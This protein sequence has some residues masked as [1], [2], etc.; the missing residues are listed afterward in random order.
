MH[1]QCNVNAPPINPIAHRFFT[2]ATGATFTLGTGAPAAEQ[3]FAGSLAAP[4]LSIV[5]NRG[6]AQTLWVDEVP[7]IVPTNAIVTLIPSQHY[8]FESPAAVVRWQFN[9]EFYCIIDH[10]PE[11]SCAGLLFYGSSGPMLLTPDADVLR[12]L[13]LMLA[14]FED[15]FRTHDAIQGEMLRTL[16]KRLIIILTR[17]ARVSA[18]G[19][20]VSHPQL[21]MIRRFNVLVEDN[22]RRLHRVSEYAALLHKS[23]KTLANLFAAH[24]RQ[25]PLQIIQE[26][27]AMQ[28][29][30]LLLYSD[31]SVK[32]IASELGFAESATFSRFFKTMATCSPQ[33][34]RASRG[35]AV[36]AHQVGTSGHASGKNCYRNVAA[37]LAE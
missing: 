30:R 34:F 17:V 13:C 7:V 12:R 21:D 14:V 1:D 10:D 37:V 35:R 22:Y 6:N 18:H 29:R 16:L 11:V 23:P 36:A 33:E 4:L 5:W 28:A 9:R 8:R 27:I 19:S 24:S 2:P 20:A 3:H 32:Q 26:R 15:E 31:K 25:T